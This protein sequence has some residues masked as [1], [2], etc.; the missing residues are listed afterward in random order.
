MKTKGKFVFFIL[1]VLLLGIFSFVLQVNKQIALAQSEQE[2]LE[3]LQ[4]D[5]ARYESEIVRLRGEADTLSN[6]VAQYNAQ[7]NLTT[8]K[9]SQTEEKIRQLGGRIDQLETSLESLTHAFNNRVIRTYKMARLNQP[10]L[11]ILTSNDLSQAVS[12]FHYIKKI[13]E[14]DRDLLTRLEQAQGIYI[15]EKSDQETLQE[16]LKEQQQILGAQ[17]NAKANLLVDTRNNEV[18]YQQLLS[19]ARSEYESIQAIIAGRGDE[20]EVSDV[21]AGQRIASVIQGPSCNSSGAHLHFIVKNS[22][23]STVNPFSF[24]KSGIGHENCSGSSCGSSDGDLFNPSGSWEWPIS[25][26]IRYT[27][28]Y[29][30]TWATRNTWVGRIYSFHNG[31]DINSKSSS[32]IKAVASGTLYQ[33]SYGG[34]NGCRL[35]YVRLDHSESDYETLY[36]HINY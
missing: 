10:Y 23:G 3:S 16:E 19:S 4:E 24:L 21:S 32:E 15:D 2:K 33:G 1:G 22:D 7:I 27:Q 29:G 36:L 30:S 12:S 28:G 9:V 6:Q 26:E 11:M 17:K 8:L 34:V 20:S 35:R 13:Q 18:R 25:P 5:I 14:S 31:I